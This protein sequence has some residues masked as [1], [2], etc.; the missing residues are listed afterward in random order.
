MELVADLLAFGEM[1]QTQPKFGP[2]DMNIVADRVL[3]TL[4]SPIAERKATIVVSHLP[5]VLGNMGELELLLQ[6][7]LDNALSS[8]STRPPRVTLSA[9]KDGKNW[10][11]FC[12]DNGS[13]I[14]QEIQKHLFEPFVRGDRSLP[15]SGLGLATC[16][17]IVNRHNV[18]I[19]IVQM[20]ARGTTV[21]VTLRAV[22]NTTTS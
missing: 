6:N 10:S 7:L 12:K 3:E 22:E 21:A 5:T 8:S 19:R 11:V 4:G 2:V 15:G 9:V 13:G 14:P 18:S 20:N 17:R 16:Q 1:D